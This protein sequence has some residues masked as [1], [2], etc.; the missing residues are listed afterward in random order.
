MLRFGYWETPAASV[1]LLTPTANEAQTGFN[2]TQTSVNSRVKDAHQRNQNYNSAAI[3]MGVVETLI[4]D[5][6]QKNGGT[7]NLKKLKIEFSLIIMLRV[8]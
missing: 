4:Y 8:L 6:V 1:K 5:P 2:L 7:Y 3:A